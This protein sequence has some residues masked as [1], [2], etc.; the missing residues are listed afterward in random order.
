MQQIYKYET[1]Y[2]ICSGEWVKKYLNIRPT[3]AYYHYITHHRISVK[4]VMSLEKAADETETRHLLK[5]KNLR[6]Y[7]LVTMLIEPQP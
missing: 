5:T 6:M 2:G 7:I 1:P 3:E 4:N